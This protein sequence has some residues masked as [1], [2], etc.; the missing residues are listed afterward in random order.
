MGGALPFTGLRV[1]DLS[2][3]AAGPVCAKVL[4]DYGATVV[5][6]ESLARLDSLRV[7]NPIP[8]G[9]EGYNGSGYFNNFNSNKL[10][11]QVDLGH[12]AGLDLARRL[13]RWAEVLVENF[14]PGVLHRWG[15]D[16]ETLSRENP[17]IIVVSAPACGSEGP[18]REYRGFGFGIKA[19]AG[20]SWLTGN[21]SR[22][23]VGPPGAFPDFV[24]N[25]GQALVGV[26]TALRARER[27][28]RGCLIELAQ[29]ESTVCVT[30]PAIAAASL[31]VPRRG[32]MMNGSPWACPHGIYPVRGADRWLALTVTTDTEWAALGRVAFGE[33][34]AADPSF[35]TLL[36]RRRR[37]DDLERAIAAWTGRHE[38]EALAAALQEAGVP[39]H[40]ANT[41]RDLLDDDPHLQARG[42]YRTLVHEELGPCRYDGAPFRLEGVAHGPFRAAPLLGGDTDTV[43][44]DLLGIGEDEIEALHASGALQ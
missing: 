23:P 18:R 42:Y 24:I 32:R 19:I 17:G 20:L 10:S 1:L 30:G 25:A 40:V 8:E 14:A 22:K 37:E 15:L 44:R 26:I 16:Y 31:G 11:L 38:G 28:G 13:G 39:A 6:V 36:G 5:R 43:L 7:N 35:A 2:W 21:P 34:W 3:F 29:Y 12:P 33:P 41:N 9:Y 4:A 27:T